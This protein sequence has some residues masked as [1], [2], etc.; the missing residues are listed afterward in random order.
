[1]FSTNHKLEV[2]GFSSRERP[3]I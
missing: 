3:D 1:V 2:F